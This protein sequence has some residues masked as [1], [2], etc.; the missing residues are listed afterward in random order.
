[1]TSFQLFQR[2][3]PRLTFGSYN[4]DNH[5]CLNLRIALHEL[6]IHDT[7]CVSFANDA[8]LAIICVGKNE[9]SVTSQNDDDFVVGWMLVGPNRSR[10]PLER[11]GI[12]LTTNPL[13]ACSNLVSAGATAWGAR[14][15]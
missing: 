3:E 4:S 10:P 6:S 2:K 5:K 14:S 1:M 15:M 11:N 13:N 12:R 8:V 9:R 7:V